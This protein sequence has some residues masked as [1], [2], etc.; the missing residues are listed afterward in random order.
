MQTIRNVVLKLFS[1]GRK[2]YFHHLKKLFFTYAA[3]I[4]FDV[5]LGFNVRKMNN[6]RI[7]F[8]LR[9][10]RRAWDKK[11]YFWRTIELRGH[12]QNAHF[13]GLSAYSL[14]NFLLNHERHAIRTNRISEKLSYKHRR[15]IIGQIRNNF[16]T[17]FEFQV[18]S[19][20]FQNIAIN[21]F[22]IGK[23]R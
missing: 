19:F 9:P 22:Y 16:K 3:K 17:R 12:R 18:T 10:K 8:R 7:N 4:F 11:R 2:S 13:S 14:S 6:R 20:K 23:I 5:M 1:S 21:N 15:N